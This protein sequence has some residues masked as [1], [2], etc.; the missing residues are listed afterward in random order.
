M[1]AH[2]SAPRH[3]AGTLYQ[4]TRSRPF[5]ATT[6]LGLLVRGMAAG[7]RDAL[8]DLH[9]ALAIDM[10][11][12]VVAIGVAQ[13][14]ADGLVASAFVEIWQTAWQ[15]TDAHAADWVAK[16]VHRRCFDHQHG[17]PEAASGRSAPEQ[18]L[19]GRS[20]VA[21]AAPRDPS[22]AMILAGLLGKPGGTAAAGGATLRLRRS[23]LDRHR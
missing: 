3:F 16:I 23:P 11:A 9:A 15:H 1:F 22:A 10:L 14:D 8:A 12:A 20:A 19:S 5:R 6:I 18:S 13:P 4:S 21:A 2:V 17:T 7:D